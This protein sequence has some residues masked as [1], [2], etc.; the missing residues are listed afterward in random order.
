MATERKGEMMK[1]A[2]I[3]FVCLAL[4]LGAT[5]TQAQDGDKSETRIWV[6]VGVGTRVVTGDTP[7]PRI[8]ETVNLLQFG[9]HALFALNPRLAIA[10]D[11]AYGWRSLDYTSSTTSGSGATISNKSE[12]NGW[13][14]NGLI[15]ATL[16]VGSQGGLLY[17][18]PG[19]AVIQAKYKIE[20]NNNGT[21]TKRTSDIGTGFGL[22]VGA[23]AI[24]PVKGK[25][26]GFFSFRHTWVVGEF[27]ESTENSS[28]KADVPI[29]GPA[30][31]VGIGYGF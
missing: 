3:M 22:V 17:A 19:L 4:L 5:T 30:A 28:L 12:S 23:G 18:G 7:A 11:W 20:A 26:H 31:L 16:P 13:N 10:A 1:Q 9:A 6:G 27:D 24:M 29:G 25:W 21:V 8:G 14:L 2:M 15:V